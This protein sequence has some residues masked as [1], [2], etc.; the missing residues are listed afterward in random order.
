MR[1]RE[2]I[3][4]YG[5]LFFFLHTHG[6]ISALSRRLFTR[7]DRFATDSGIMKSRDVFMHARKYI[8][9]RKCEA[10]KVSLA[11]A[12]GQMRR[13]SRLAFYDPL[14]RFEYFFFV[15]LAR[16]TTSR[17]ESILFKI[18]WIKLNRD[19]ESSGQLLSS[20]NTNIRNPFLFSMKEQHGLRYIRF[21][22]L[23]KV[24]IT[25]RLTALMRRTFLNVRVN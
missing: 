6:K 7:D 16:F 4:L 10:I 20:T 2:A 8:G 25:L 3:R 11:T 15:S 22:G 12:A 5:F 24:T 19:R 18:L 13:K 21:H 14:M 1:H 23:S 9:A 17:V